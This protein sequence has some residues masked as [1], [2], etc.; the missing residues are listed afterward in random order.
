MTGTVVPWSR[1]KNLPLLVRHHGVRARNDRA[2][3]RAAAACIRASGRSCRPPRGIRPRCG[4]STGRILVLTDG[5][6][7]HRAE[8]G[9]PRAGSSSRSGTMRARDS[10]QLRRHCA[11]HVRIGP[12][13]RHRA[14]APRNAAEF[15]RE[16]GTGISAAFVLLAMMLPLGLIAF[17]PMGAYAVEAGLR[18]ALAAA[19]FGNLTAFV[20]SGALLPNE[21]PRASSV[22]LFAAFILRLPEGATRVRRGRDLPR[23]AVPRVTGIIQIAV[24]PA[25]PRQHRALRALSGRRRTDDRAR[26]FA[27]LVR[28]SRRCSARTAGAARRRRRGR[29]SRRSTRGRCWSASSPSSCS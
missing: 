18:A 1:R 11:T 3:D 22:F 13:T 26:D 21:V 2:R 6:G 25:A 17:A 12:I 4:G 28:D 27:H 19:I 14:A 23:R 24:R 5:D 8:H 7:E 15:A 9:V 10:R 16:I 20:L 29:A